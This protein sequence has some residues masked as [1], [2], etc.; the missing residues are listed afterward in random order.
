MPKSLFYQEL[1]DNLSALLS[2]ENDLI[3]SLANT[4]ALLFEKLDTINWVGFY[5]NDGDSLVL[6]PF[7]GKI[8]CVRIG[9]GKGV[10]G[11][12]YSENRILSVKRMSYLLSGT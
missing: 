11:T 9:F 10:C 3:A 1:T 2:G 8:A 7:Q 4:S 6:G 5:L 12:A